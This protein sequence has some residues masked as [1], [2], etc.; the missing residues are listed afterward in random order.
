MRLVSSAKL[1]TS[2]EHWRDRLDN[3]PIEHR[4]LIEGGNLSARFSKLPLAASHPV[5]IG[6]F[7]GLLL[8]TILLLPFAY[9]SGWDINKWLISWLLYSLLLILMLSLLG[10]LS[11]QIVKITKRMPVV[12]PRMIIYLSPFLGLIILTFS[13]GISIIPTWAKDVGLIFMI[14]P[15]PVYVHLSWAPRWRLLELIEQNI[16]PFDFL[17]QTNIVN[18]DLELSEI[19][20]HFSEEE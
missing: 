8:S 20:E 4:M 16:N 2:I 7:Y 13:I 18:E 17:D 14:F 3:F 11:S 19:I 6:A 15:G 12:V 10:G 9:E 1:M 5:F